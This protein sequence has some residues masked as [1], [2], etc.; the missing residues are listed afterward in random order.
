MPTYPSLPILLVDD[1]E[2]FLLSA[3]LTLKSAGMNHV[4][5]CSDSR[6]VMELLAS[7]DFSLIMM[8]MMMPHISGRELVPQI[9]REYPNVPVIILTAVNEVETAVEAMKSGALDYIVKPVDTSRLVSSIRR[10]VEM[11]EMRNENRLLKKYLLSGKLENPGAFSEIITQDNAMRAIFQYLEAIARTPLPV[12]ITG[13]TGVGKELIARVI[14]DLSQRSGEFVAVNVAGLDDNLFSDTLFGHK[15][16]AFTGADAPRKGLIEQAGEGTLFLDEIGDLGIESQIKLLRLLQE[17]KYYPLGADVARMIDARIVVAT[18]QNLEKMQEEGSFRK[19]LY[20]R[21]KFHQVHIPP[22]R[23]RLEDVPLLAEHFLEK[24]AK[25]L[26]KKKPTAPRELFVLLKTYHFPG[27]IRELEGMIFDAVSQH[28]SG[29]LSMETFKPHISAP[30]KPG[31]SEKMPPAAAAGSG[32]SVAFGE[33]LPSMK[34]VENL[35]IEE[36]LKRADGNQTIAA[37]LIG[38]TRKALNNRLIRSRG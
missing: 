23:E 30:A 5:R 13:E 32:G 18:N 38:M 16:G 31:E 6:K 24:A 35:L 27:N 20:Y 33:Q 17:G 1:E 36:A 12:L 25:R 8:D 19:D 10:A 4:V 9:I 29:V 37:R 15:K 22:L 2:Q 34:E 26:G 3:T 21:L 14:H 11:R 7:R 28:K